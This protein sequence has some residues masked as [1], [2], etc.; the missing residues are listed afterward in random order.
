[1]KVTIA[2]PVLP[3]TLNEIIALCKESFHKYARTKDQYTQ[4]CAIWAGRYPAFPGKVWLSFVWHVR[5]LRRDPADNTPAAAKFVLDGLVD[6]GILKDDSGFVIQ[7]P[8]VH[9]WELSDK[10]GVL[11]TI[12]DRPIYQLSEIAHDAR[13]LG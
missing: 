12:S 5:T 9:S 8:V 3:P 6:A 11:L 7:P 2:F 4:D 10:E 1:M 13:K